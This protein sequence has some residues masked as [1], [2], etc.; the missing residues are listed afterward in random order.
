M[1]KLGRSRV[2][3]IVYNLADRV[4]RIVLQEVDYLTWFLIKSQVH[5]QVRDC[6]HTQLALLVA[7]E[8]YLHE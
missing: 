8:A 4:S 5:Y 6:V 7:Q 3:K 2:D 1:N